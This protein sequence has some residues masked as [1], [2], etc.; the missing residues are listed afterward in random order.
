MFTNVEFRT[1]Y[2]KLFYLITFRNHNKPQ[3]MFLKIICSLALASCLIWFYFNR[4]SQPIIG[5]CIT[6]IGLIYAMYNKKTAGPPASVPNFK[7]KSG[8][9]SINTQ[10]TGT[11]NVNVKRDAK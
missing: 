11:I 9:N 6:S 10:S 4:S 5:I 1:F 8:K 3:T 2:F 7:I